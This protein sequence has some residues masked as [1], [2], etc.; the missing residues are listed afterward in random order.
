M[1]RALLEKA[2]AVVHDRLIASA[3]PE[4]RAAIGDVLAK[5]SKEVGAR[6]GTRDYRAAQRVVLGLGQ[7]NRLNETTL[8]GFCGERKFEEAVVTLAALAKIQIEIVDRLMDN[9]RFDPVLILCKA[10]NLSWP[11]V[12]AVIMLRSVANGMSAFGLDAA[13]TNYG[14]LSASTARRVVRFWQVR[15]ANGA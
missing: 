13:L 4:M 15:Q 9:D 5:V 2:T 11:A 1:F 8:L 3:T 7:A 14:R 6:A 10:A 12:K